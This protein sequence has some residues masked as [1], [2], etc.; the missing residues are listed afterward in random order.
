MNSKEFKASI[1]VRTTFPAGHYY[2]PIV[3]PSQIGDHLETAYNVSI[4]G[5]SGIPIEPAAMER[6]WSGQL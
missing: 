3:D 4:E 1:G 6:M 5:L 2:S